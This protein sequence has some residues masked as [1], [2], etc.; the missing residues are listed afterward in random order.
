MVASYIILSNQ[1]G[2]DMLDHYE[3]PCVNQFIQKYGSIGRV[4]WQAWY[5]VDPFRCAFAPDEYLG[6]SKRFLDKLCFV[7]TGSVPTK[8]SLRGVKELVR[9]SFHP[10]QIIHGFASSEDVYEIARRIWGAHQDGTIDLVF[11]GV[12]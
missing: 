1:G 8:P 3:D 4:V 6:Y 9:F 5:D 2:P 7:Y 10:S 11:D 12:D